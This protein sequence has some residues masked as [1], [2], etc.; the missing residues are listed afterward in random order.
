MFELTDIHSLTHFQRNTKEHILRLKATGRPVV[1]TVNGRAQLVIQDA[2]SYQKLLEAVEQKQAFDG[3]R[4]GLQSMRRGQGR[5]LQDALKNL[6][7][8]H[9]SRAR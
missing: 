3:V 5:P 7:K 4:R 6:R 2:H 1:L 8:K 9:K